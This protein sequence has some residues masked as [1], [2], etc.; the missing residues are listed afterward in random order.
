VSGSLTRAAKSARYGALFIKIGADVITML[1]SAIRAH[2]QFDNP[3][4]C[5][6]M[7]VT[8]SLILPP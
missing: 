3:V 5:S 8:K 6:V 1:P 2:A 4:I 7:A